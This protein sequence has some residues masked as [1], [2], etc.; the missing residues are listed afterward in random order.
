MCV[1]YVLC[2]V[3]QYPEEV[4]VAEGGGGAEVEYVDMVDPG[5]VPDEHVDS[6]QPDTEDGHGAEAVHGQHLA[7]PDR[8]GHL[9]HLALQQQE[10]QRQQDACRPSS[11]LQVG[12]QRI[13]IIEVAGDES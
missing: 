1:C 4:D 5:A 9:L 8:T 13:S 6:P 12:R 7:P 10:H 11:H 2:V 3:W